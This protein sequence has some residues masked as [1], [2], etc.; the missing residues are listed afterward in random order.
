MG[1]QKRDRKKPSHIYMKLTEIL[2]QLGIEVVSQR[3][4]HEKEYYG[5]DFYKKGVAHYE[6]VIYLSEEKTEDPHLTVIFSEE[7]QAAEIQAG[8]TQAEEAEQDDYVIT[9]T[10]LALCFERLHRYFLEMDEKWFLVQPFI[11]YFLGENGH[12]IKKIAEKAAEVLENPVIITNAA[13]KVLAINDAGEKVED[14][15]FDSALQ[16]GYCSAE[17]IRIFE[18]EGITEKVLQTE[19]AFLLSTGLAEKIPRVLAKVM[20]NG[21]VAAYVGVLQVKRKITRQD[22]NMTELLC[23]ILQK[24]IE[25]DAALLDP[26]NIIYE[27]IIRD[28]LSGQI[29]TPF[30]LQE[31]LKASRWM[32]KKYFRCTLIATYNQYKQIDN[33]S[34]L[35][36][37]ISATLAVK[38]IRYHNNI[39]ILNN[40]DSREQWHRQ[41]NMIEREA[42][43]LS[44]KLGV[45]NEFESLLDLGQYYREALNAAEIAM[46]LKA[47]DTVFYFA[48]F[49]PY[50]LISCVD[51]DVLKACR[52]TYYSRLKKYDEKHHTSYIET[53]YYFILYNCSIQD[54]AKKMCV[55][56][57]TMAHR[58]EK[59]I[60][61]TNIPIQNGIVLQNFVLFHQ[62]QMY[63]MRVEE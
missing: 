2:K 34:Y 39:L 50:Y 35:V 8:E 63:L 18:Y 54:A 26:T 5:V 62:I 27:S 38:V 30:V 52:N 22:L 61:I 29:T 14:P 31:R 45:S 33:I 60:E 53:L 49:L 48:A 41:I 59:I 47:R 55:H 15:V 23:Q 36:N 43:I 46:I 42:K 19:H 1:L 11:S 57:N 56:R 9:K 10:P 7:A 37:K 16:S 44:L 32:T 25:R 17:S 4:T 24:E 20:V 40:Y 13:Y 28:V 21:K 6:N 3:I 51:K 58:I 12:D